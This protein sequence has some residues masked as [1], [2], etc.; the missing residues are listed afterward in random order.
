MSRRTYPRTSIGLTAA[1]ETPTYVSIVL[2]PAPRRG[3]DTGI[4]QPN[5]NAP[6]DGPTGFARDER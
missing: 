5:T 4:G 6:S 1:K 2:L 3:P